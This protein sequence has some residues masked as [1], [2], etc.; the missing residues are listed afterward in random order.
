MRMRWDCVW[1]RRC[2]GPDNVGKEKKIE[3]EKIKEKKRG[4]LWTFRHFRLAG[5]VVLPNGLRN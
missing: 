2:G 3:K 1:L 4:V 5:E